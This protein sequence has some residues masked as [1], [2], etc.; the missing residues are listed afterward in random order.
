MRRWSR[1]SSK[2]VLQDRWIHVTADRCE[3][4]PDQIIEPFY[5]NQTPPEIIVPKFM[6]YTGKQFLDKSL[7]A[8]EIQ[9][10]EFANPSWMSVNGLLRYW[11]L[12]EQGRI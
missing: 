7:D 8:T 10:Y 11:K 6:E 3:L 2:V 5:V 12:K 1:I 4:A 9:T